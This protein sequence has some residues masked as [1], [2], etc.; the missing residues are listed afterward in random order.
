MKNEATQL[1]AETNNNQGDAAMETKVAIETAETTTPHTGEEV[2][3]EPTVVK[4]AELML[5]PHKL[6]QFFPPMPE[7]EI[8][9]LVADILDHG[10][11]YPIV[12]HDGCILDGRARLTACKRAGVEP[13]LVKLPE[14]EDPLD[15]LV[16]VSLRRKHFSD[17]QRIMISAGISMELAKRSKVLR[18]KTASNAR[19]HGKKGDASGTTAIPKKE[20]KERANETVAKLFNVS[21]TAVK[22]ATRLI[23]ESPAAA[24]AVKNGTAS[25][26]KANRE[27]WAAK[28]VAE[29]EQAATEFTTETQNA[30]DKVCQL[31]HTDFR[32]LLELRPDL[33]G[34][35]DYLVSDI[36]YE[37]SDLHLV[38]ELGKFAAEVLKP[39]GQ[40]VLMI[41][42]AGL[43]PVVSGI[44]QTPELEWRWMLSSVMAG[45]GGV[46]TMHGIYNVNQFFKPILIFRKIGA[47][48]PAF[49][50]K[51]VIDS[52][53]KS[54]LKGI[55]PHTQSHEGFVNIMRALDVRPNSLILDCFGGLFT[56]GMAALRMNCKFV[57]CDIEKKYV[58]FGNKRLMAE[59]SALHPSVV[60]A[61][62]LK[63]AA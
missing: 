2:A 26:K 42:T 32:Q 16:S 57:G 25:F 38:P 59:W 46:S 35:V 53:P 41:G 23:K 30:F 44:L 56:T 27:V 50:S 3:T 55:H 8:D 29:I 52:G 49:I 5:K 1:N 54:D 14:N 15:Y 17:D 4:M 21:P 58:E 12:T 51:D 24:L 9:N 10:L 7:K 62:A 18:A 39:G 36:P 60:V 63:E 48:F 31:Y 33:R 19:H 37:F 6:A 47:D 11:K 43:P 13:V 40:M 22:L 20:P 61:E 28:K 34:Q 45:G